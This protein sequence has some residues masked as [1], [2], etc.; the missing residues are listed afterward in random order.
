MGFLRLVSML[1][2]LILAGC[3]VNVQGTSASVGTFSMTDSRED[4]EET[5]GLLNNVMENNAVYQKTHRNMHHGRM[6]VSIYPKSTF[7]RPDGIYCRDYHEVIIFYSKRTEQ[8]GTA[9]RISGQWVPI[10]NSLT[11]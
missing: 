7:Q 11:D 8:D 9:C 1:S 5:L 6:L 4:Q 2:S 10:A 3:S